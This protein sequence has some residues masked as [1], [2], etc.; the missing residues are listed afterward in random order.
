MTTSVDPDA[1]VLEVRGITC[2]FK[3]GDG[4]FGKRKIDAVN[5]VDLALYPNEMVALVGESGSGK[6]TLARTIAG[7]EKPRT[8]TIYYR[9]RPLDRRHRGQMREFRRRRSIV[10]QNPYASLSPRM[11]VGAALAEALTVA[12]VVPKPQIPAEVD[13]LLTSV[14]L[15]TSY[16]NKYPLALSG[17]ERQRVAI[18]R[19]I[20]N[21]PDVL[22]ADEVTS[23]LDVSVSAH[24]L[25]L[26][27]DLRSQRNFTCLFITH[28]LPLALA[29]ADR[30]VIMR[31]GEIVDSGT[32]DEVMRLST[33]PYTRQL[34]DLATFTALNP[35]GSGAT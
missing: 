2:T 8:G 6:T 14:G 3:V 22:I 24:I 27:M 35:S 28:D 19:A 25:N 21:H 34:L 5:N 12:G 7:L 31:S 10:F 9:G 30:V 29:V 15:P 16:R 11:K 1:P 23:A 20:S 4:W 33:H 13:R 26:L 32:P 18:A 17:G